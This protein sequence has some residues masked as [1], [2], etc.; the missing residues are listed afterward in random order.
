MDHGL[1]ADGLEDGQSLDD[2]GRADL[3]FELHAQV[4]DDRGRELAQLVGPDARFEVLLPQADV[5][6]AGG[7]RKVRDRVEAPP[8]LHELPQRLAAGVEV[9]DAGALDAATDVVAEV[10]CIG[11]AI[12]R[13]A[14]TPAPLAPADFPSPVR[15]AVDVHAAHPLTSSS[16]ARRAAR[17]P[18]RACLRV[19]AG[20]ETGMAD[21]VILLMRWSAR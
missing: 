6:V 1:L 5:D 16:M 10:R 15:L 11:L 7:G 18:L 20:D 21:R 13:A 4:G 9:G 2:G 14:T 3:T 12:E 8:L 17:L 19:E